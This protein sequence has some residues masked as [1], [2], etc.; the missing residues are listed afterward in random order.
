MTLQI[1]FFGSSLVSSYWNGAATY[2]R[3]IVK[4]LHARG[5][6]VTFY[7]PNAY[8]RQQHRDIDDPPWARV[9][10]YDVDDASGVQRCLEA[11][12]RADVVIK[13]SGVGVFDVMLE[14]SVLEL[15]RPGSQ[16]LFWDVDAPATLDRMHDDP[17][18]PLRAC[19]P[20]YDCILTY[21]GGDSVVS[22]Y[23][24]LGAKACIPIYNALD[25]SEHKPVPQEP[26][27]DG[28]L[29]FMASRLP[30]RE[31]RVQEFFFDA[32]ERL[33]EQRFVLG[34]T[35]WSEAALPA[36]VS[37]VGHVFTRD[38]NAF[39]STPRAIL[40]VNRA[41]MARYGFSPPTRIF[42]A[43]GAAACIISDRWDGIEQFLEP[44]AEVLLASSGADVAG[45]LAELTNRRASEI[46]AAARRRVLAH[47][48]YRQ[49]VAQLNAVLEGLQPGAGWAE[50]RA[51]T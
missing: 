35:G 17:S 28:S 23:R 2:Y 19:V 27:F 43:A 20:K 40:N 14:R 22:A 13:A 33:P 48:T 11:A 42:E 10:V 44:G 34:G 29:G 12:R 38:H 3:G 47:H 8:Q 41:S 6:R 1:A 16:V 45:L 50:R 4:E 26:R 15:K 49:R 51:T 30:D 46:G 25:P 18:D 7:E 21:G 37:W 24:R 39:N 31:A 5:H 32:A 9:V 36:N